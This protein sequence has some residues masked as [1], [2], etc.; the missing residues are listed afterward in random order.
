MQRKVLEEIENE[1]GESALSLQVLNNLHYLELVIKESLR[2]YPSVPYF[3]RKLAEEVSVGGYTIPKDTNVTISPYLMGRDPMIFPNPLVFNPHRFDVETTREKINPF[4]YIPFSAG[5]RNCIGQKFA[6]YEM[7][8]IICKIVRHFEL[9]VSEENMAIKI[10][11]DL[12]LKPVEGVMII[13][14]KRN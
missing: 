3:G 9:S 14:K 6:V 4:A 5:P 7:K 2:L 11:G 13:I 10:Y 8:S 1:I 12:V